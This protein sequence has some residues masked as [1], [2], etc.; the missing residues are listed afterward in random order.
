MEVESTGLFEIIE[1][2]NQENTMMSHH[3]E[4]G[5]LYSYKDPVSPMCSPDGPL[6][7]PWSPAAPSSSSL[8]EQILEECEDSTIEK[9]DHFNYFMSFLYLDPVQTMPRPCPDPAQNLTRP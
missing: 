2:K 3:G 1:T 4:W 9:V 5:E 7:E 8:Q 6:T